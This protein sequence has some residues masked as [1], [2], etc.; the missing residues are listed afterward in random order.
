MFSFH[1]DDREEFQLGSVSKKELKDLVN[2]LTGFIDK[3]FFDYLS[4]SEATNSKQVPAT[5]ENLNESLITPVKQNDDLFNAQKEP[6]KMQPD[7]ST[8]PLESK[9]YGRIESPTLLNQSTTFFDPNAISTPGKPDFKTNHISS[10]HQSQQQSFD[11][12]NSTLLSVNESLPPTQHSYSF[13]PLQGNTAIHAPLMSFAGNY[14][15]SSNNIS[16]PYNQVLITM[17]S[18]ATT[19]PAMPSA[20]LS[21]YLNQETECSLTTKRPGCRS[22]RS[23]FKSASYKELEQLHPNAVDPH[24]S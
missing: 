14:N 19:T 9:E 2:E 18:E 5:E 4:Y 22:K 7:Q 17:P 21:S 10:E 3:T 12:F 11:S 15:V 20:M 6:N 8:L 1:I 16:A 13:S 23:R 24:V